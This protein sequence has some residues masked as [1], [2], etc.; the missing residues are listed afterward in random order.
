MALF[1]IFTNPFHVWFKGGQVAYDPAPQ[2]LPVRAAITK[3]H[4]P[5]ASLASL[6][7]QF[8]RPEVQDQSIGGGS[9]RGSVLVDDHLL[10]GSSQAL[11]L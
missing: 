2:Q 8:L 11:P 4:R 10:M 3:C 9:L 7:S 5:K 6:F 1:S